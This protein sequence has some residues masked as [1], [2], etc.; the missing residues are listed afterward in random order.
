MLLIHIKEKYLQFSKTKWLIC[1]F[2]RSWLL[3]PRSHFRRRWW[4]RRWNT[5]TKL[6]QS[7]DWHWRWLAVYRC[8][9]YS[10]RWLVAGWEDIG[11]VRAND[12]NGMLRLGCR[13]GD[14]P[15]PEMDLHHLTSAVPIC[16]SVTLQQTG[17]AHPILGKCWRANIYPILGAR[18]LFAGGPLVS[19][20]CSTTRS[21]IDCSE[22]FRC[23]EGRTGGRDCM[24]NG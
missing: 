10:G 15:P 20:R 21:I 22:S 13:K 23:S 19:S 11:T 2:N 6:G 17:D 18:L 7:W 24:N 1:S 14:P 5:D 12:E 3:K 16:D 4:E 8:R 9:C